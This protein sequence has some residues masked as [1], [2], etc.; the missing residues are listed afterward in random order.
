MKTTLKNMLSRSLLVLGLLVSV[1]AIQA[2]AQTLDHVSFDIPFEFHVGNKT[3]AP[4][5][6]VVQ[7]RVNHDPLLFKLHSV[8][9]KSTILIHTFAKLSAREPEISQ[10][11]FHRYDNQYFLRQVRRAGTINHQELA[12]SRAE[13][14]L[15][16]KADNRNDH[17]A[18][19]A[20]S[21]TWRQR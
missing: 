7:I 5:G 13:K 14:E 15:I 1:T 6:Y 2:S 3:F 18:L 9:N 12:A 8:D 20:V 17:L 10:L 11:I 16:K 19:G 21:K 4:G